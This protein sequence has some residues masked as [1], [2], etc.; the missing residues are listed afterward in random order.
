MNIKNTTLYQ[1]IKADT[2]EW[3]KK[4]RTIGATVSAVALALLAAN[5]VGGFELPDVLEDPCQWLAVA[6]ITMATISSTAKK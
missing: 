1:R 3:F 6:G 4:A 5:H 2:P